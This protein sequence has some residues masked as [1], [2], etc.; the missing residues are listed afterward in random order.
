MLLQNLQKDENSNLPNINGLPK[1]FSKNSI[2]FKGLIANDLI[3]LYIITHVTSLRKFK[4]HRAQRK[5]PTLNY[6][7]SKRNVVVNNCLR[8][9][10]NMNFSAHFD[11]KTIK[12]PFPFF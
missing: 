12:N 11:R 3:R 5:L 4:N 6:K 7:T 9:F 2:I 1:N 8:I 10:P